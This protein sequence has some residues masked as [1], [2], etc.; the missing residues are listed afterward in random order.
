MAVEHPPSP[1]IHGTIARNI[2]IE[3]VGGTRKPGEVLGSEIEVSEGLGISRTAYREAIRILAAKGLVESRPK[4]GTRITP[5]ARWNLLDPDILAWAFEGEPDTQFVVDLFELRGVIEPAAAAFA[6]SRRSEADIVE[7]SAALALM[8]KHGLADERGR[9]GD[10]RFPRAILVAARNEPLAALASTV[11]A[12]VRWT[13]KFKHRRR[14]LPR[15]P[16][17]DHRRVQEAILAGDEDAAR[18]AMAALLGL[19]LAD[20]ELPGGS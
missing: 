20:M 2:G 15:D 14:R 1:R 6:A 18:D 11:G 12:A 7:M 9:D 5:R 10:Q 19:A 16:L 3:I 4:A 8:E 17:P 13:T